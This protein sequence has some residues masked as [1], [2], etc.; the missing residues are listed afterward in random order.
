MSE[1]LSKQ[2]IL[3]VDDI[4]DN[5]MVLDEILH[6]RY[7][8]RAANSGE[9]ALKLAGS[10]PKP[11]IILLDVMMPEMDGFEVC[12]RLKADEATHKIPII[13]VTAMGDVQDEEMGLV[14]GAVDYITKPVS[15]P[16]V[17][18]RVKTHLALYDQSRVLEEKVIE[19]TSQLEAAQ[20]EVVEGMKKLEHAQ[21]EILQRLAQAGEFR[22]DDT[23]QHTHRVGLV[24][25]LMAQRLGLSEF[26][27][28]MILRAAPLHDVGKIGIPDEIL[29]KPGKL[30]EEEFAIMKRHAPMGA[31]ILQDGKSTLVCMAE[32]IALT[33][34]E[35]WNGK[36]YPN[37]LSGDAIPIEGQIVGIVDV[38]DAL[39]H[40]RPY[41]KAWTIE[42]TLNE[43]ERVRDVHFSSSLV[44]VFLQLPHH[45]L[46]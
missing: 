45:E 39:T 38:F 22:D 13:F 32:I 46:L 27:C 17:L 25:C 14:L 20:S 35:R 2:V 15:A 44:D 43:L 6:D 7:K 28:D 21:T 40:A 9:K 5:I 10:D 18:A 33:H 36:G 12:R 8:V 4:A 29:L 24:A 34:H 16:I 23:G 31:Q 42:E 1:I 26:Q 41:K 11:D 3:V 19:R 37:G 30:T